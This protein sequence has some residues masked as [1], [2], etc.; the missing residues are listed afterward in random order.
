[1]SRA[2]PE[3]YATGPAHGTKGQTDQPPPERESPDEPDDAL[4]GNPER[5]E[6]V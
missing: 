2:A 3:A 6:P 4:L 1:M 5:D